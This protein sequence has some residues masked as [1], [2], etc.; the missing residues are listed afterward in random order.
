NRLGRTTLDY[1]AGYS[2]ADEQV[3]RDLRFRYELNDTAQFASS[4]GRSWKPDVVYMGVGADPNDPAA[5]E[6]DGIVEREKLVE[7]D[8]YEVALN[9]RY[10][11][12]PDRQQF[13]KTG[14]RGR[15][16]EKRV[17]FEFNESTDNPASVDLLS[18]MTSGNGRDASDM[19]FPLI[20]AYIRGV[21]ERERDAFA[22]ERNFAD[23]VAGDSSSSED[24]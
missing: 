3:P 1:Q 20:D 5:Y 7:E 6:F 16:K 13:L 11:F 2:F 14:V 4:N 10:D 15:F 22:V 18:S 21:F 23:S 19:D 8:H 9:A 24:V 12:G 17:G